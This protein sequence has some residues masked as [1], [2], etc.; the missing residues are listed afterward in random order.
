LPAAVGD[1]RFARERGAFGAILLYDGECGFCTRSVLFVYRR[2][3]KARIR[4]ASL[5]SDVGQKLLAEHGI[6]LDMSTV[7]L[8][9]EKG[10]HVRSTAVLRT[11]RLLRWPWSWGYAAILVPRFVRDPLYR[12]VAKHRRK[13]GPSVDACAVP[14]PELRARM[15]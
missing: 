1:P 10:A 11:A 9:D 3:P 2:D 14:T 4:F 8:V 6:P 12:L 13:L 7:A 5:Q 15:L